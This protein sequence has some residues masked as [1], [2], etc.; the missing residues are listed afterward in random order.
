MKKAILWV[1][2]PLA[3]G[4]LILECMGLLKYGPSIPSIITSLTSGRL[5][6]SEET[7]DESDQPER[8]LTVNP[9]FD[10]T[11][12]KFVIT[13]SKDDSRAVLKIRQS[14]QYEYYDD[15]GDA[16]ATIRTEILTGGGDVVSHYRRTQAKNSD[17]RIKREERI[18]IFSYE[19]DEISEN[20]F[21]TSYAGDDSIIRDEGPI[22]TIHP[23]Y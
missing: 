13:E 7:L 21:V 9:E 4:A 14:I 20:F 17:S 1:I 3:V 8:I 6:Q 16:V 5:S 2:I 23:R 11:N 10:G 12:Q 19:S 18:Y 22:Q 15:N